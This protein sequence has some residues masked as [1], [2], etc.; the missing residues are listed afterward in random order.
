MMVAGLVRPNDET[1]RHTGRVDCNLDARPR[2]PAHGYSLG[3]C[4]LAIQLNLVPVRVADI[5]RQAFVLLH[6]LLR[7]ALR[8]QRTPHP[9]CVWRWDEKRA[10]LPASSAIRREQREPLLPDPKPSFLW[11]P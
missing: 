8:H 7:K 9:L 4:S 1:T 11:P 3:G 2:S 10:V 5:D 6:R